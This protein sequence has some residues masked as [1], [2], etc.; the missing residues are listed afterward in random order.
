MEKLLHYLDLFRMPLFVTLGM[1]LYAIFH[2]MFPVYYL[3]LIIIIITVVVGSFRVV[4][5]AIISLFHK[6]SSLDYI[7]LLAIIVAFIS[8]EYFV[9]AIIV[10][11]LTGGQTLEEYGMRQ[12]RQSLTALIDRIPNSVFLW[13]NNHLSEKIA[14]SNVLIGQ[15]IAIRKGEAIPLDGILISN[16]GMVDESSLTGEPFLIEKIKGDQIRS[17]TINIGEMI[18]VK[19]T[20]VEKD[21]TYNKIIEIVKK[22]QKEK[23]PL[24]RLADRYSFFFTVITLLIAGGA[25]LFF[26]SFDH[27]LAV[28]VI[29]TPCPLILATPI[30]LIGGVNASA[31]RRIIMKK[32]ASIETLSKINTIVFDKTGT[33]TLGKPYVKNVIILDTSYNHNNV[34]SIAEAIERNSL[35]P[36]AKSIVE[37]ARQKKLPLKHAT[38]I[39]EK[40]GEGISGNVDGISYTL[41]KI[42]EHT[43][44]A[45][46]IIS[47]NKRIAIIV[48]EDKLK[49]ASSEIMKRLQQLGLKLYLFT[50]DKQK[51]AENIVKQLG[52]EVIVRADLN[53][54]EKKNG[55]EELKK[56][57]K[58]IA[59]V[60][61][62]INDAPALATADVGM[63]FSHEENTAASEAADIVFLG[64]DFSSVT[65]VIA[66]AKRTIHIAMQSI[67]FGIGI[68]I[69]GMIFAAFGFIPIIV[70]AVIQECIDVIVIV[71][72]LRAA[73]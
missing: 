36:L 18:V 49:E 9:A 62:G 46:Q 29:A 17:G 60:G 64:G 41:S 55:I 8:Q 20:K 51:A 10:L 12:A 11:M 54:E 52:E 57:N 35:H 63:V 47:N 22:A 53:P 45:M 44:M 65:L 24:I 26:H 40:I 73:K 15:T 7:A 27:V 50:G 19:I 1:A 38:N 25:Y 39:K 3:S 48:F 33:I 72:A 43:G 71:N 59:M 67:V 28:L 61:D 69:I 56:Q 23:A 31:R 66:I 2:Y 70:G 32:I 21:S 6:K 42:K 5:D 34:C 30:A 4:K 68:S 14:V 37:Y 58:I 13:Q 16:N